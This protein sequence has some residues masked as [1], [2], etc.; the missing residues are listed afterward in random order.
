[1]C[2]YL[3]YVVRAGGR[4]IAVARSTQSKHT[5][6]EYNTYWFQNVRKHTCKP[7]RLSVM[8]ETHIS[9]VLNLNEREPKSITT[10]LH[11]LE[12]ILTLA[13]YALSHRVN[14]FGWTHIVLLLS[15]TQVNHC[16]YDTHEIHVTANHI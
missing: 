2:L 6:Y 15:M 16:T 3:C 12:F 9:R 7:C 10:M 8:W 13:Y 14:V 5:V 11:Q 4:N 1:M